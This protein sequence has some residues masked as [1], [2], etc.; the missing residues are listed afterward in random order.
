MLKRTPVRIPVESEDGSLTF[1]DSYMD[2]ESSDPA[3]FDELTLSKCV[4]TGIKPK[5]LDINASGKLGSDDVINQID[6]TFSENASSFFE[7]K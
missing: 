3:N 7:S 2:V 1:R 4:E 6:A 5:H